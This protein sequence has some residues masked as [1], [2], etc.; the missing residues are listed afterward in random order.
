MESWEAHVSA[1][2]LRSVSVQAAEHSGGVDLSVELRVMK[3]LFLGDEEQPSHEESASVS[4]MMRRKLALLVMR[5][6]FAFLFPKACVNWA[7]CTY[8]LGK[9]P[10]N[11]LHANKLRRRLLS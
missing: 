9:V 2:L 7:T 6:R 1:R 10:G 8:T 3:A 4:F 11:D 5:R